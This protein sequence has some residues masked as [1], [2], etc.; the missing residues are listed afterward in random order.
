MALFKLSVQPNK[1][2]FNNWKFLFQ[3]HQCELTWPYWPFTALKKPKIANF[4]KFLKWG[5]NQV[6]KY[7][8]PEKNI[9]T[10]RCHKIGFLLT[11]IDVFVVVGIIFFK[12]NSKMPKIGL[13][14]VKNSAIWQLALIYW[15]NP[16]DSMPKM[17]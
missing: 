15:T 3:T 5:S 13:E 9:E 11:K 14:G 1:F 16:T 6:C 4:S 2:W 12:Q 17:I 8:N 10:S 7:F